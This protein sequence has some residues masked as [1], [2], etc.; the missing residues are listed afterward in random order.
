M[1]LKRKSLKRS[2]SLLAL[3]AILSTSAK[4]GEVYPFNK[5]NTEKIFYKN[6]LLKSSEVI[7]EKNNFFQNHNYLLSSLI[8]NPNLLE[9][10]G[11][12]VSL[13]FKTS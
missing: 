8:S 7:Q 6:T 5:F 9:I 2:F 13:V 11:P 10:N 4:S 1:P 12:S 3:T